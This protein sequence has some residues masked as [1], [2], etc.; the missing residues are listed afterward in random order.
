MREGSKFEKV[1]DNIREFVKIR[2]ERTQPVITGW[3]VITRKNVHELTDI[4][5]LSKDLGLDYITMQTFVSDWGKDDMKEHTHP[6]KVENRS[7]VLE[8]A[9]AD[10]ERV[11]AEE[12]I[13]VRV[14]RFDY[15]STKN[16]CP[17]PWTGSY[18]AA[19]GDV[20][21]CCIVADSDIVKLGNVFETSFEE[22]WNSPAYRE[23]RRQIAGD[24]IPHYCNNC[25]SVKD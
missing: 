11:G 15:Y 2:G 13:D 4:V 12:G 16:K 17:W 19:N 3:T 10:A 22:I 24:D 21:P 9:V 1:V 14:A 6:V 7:E 23:L 8:R 18:I 20:V 25:Y 5:R